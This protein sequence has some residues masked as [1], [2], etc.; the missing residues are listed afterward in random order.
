M[1][2]AAD[3][4]AVVYE[5]ERLRKD[6][7]RLFVDSSA[8]VVKD[9]EG[10]VQYVVLNDRDITPIKYRREAELLQARFRGV[11][12]A[13]PDAIV[14]VDP[15]GRMALVTP[16][17]ERLFGYTREELLGQPV[18][19]LIPDRFRGRHEGH[20]KGYF[21]DP[22]TRTMGSGLELA[23]RRRDG[24]EFPVEI[25]LSLLAIEGATLAMAAIRDVT[26]QKKSERKFRDVLE[27]APDA[28]IIVDR[29][30]RITI[31]NSQTEQVF[32]YSR[33]ELIG[34]PIELLVPTRFH[35]V[36]VSHR[37]NFFGDP[38]RRPMGSGLA[39]SGR[40]KDGTEF[41]VEIS[42]SPV[43]TEEGTL[44]TAAVRDITERVRLEE[45]RRDSAARKVEAEA[46]AKHAGELA[47]SNAELEQF[48]Y[49]ASHD[50][51]EPLRTVGS[52]AQLLAQ[53]YHGRLD[54]EADEF[55]DFVVAAVARMQTM[56]NDLLAFSRVGTRGKPF[57]ATDLEEV[58]EE[59]IANLGRSIEEGGA[60]ITHDPLP[61]VACDRAQLVQVFQNL[62]ANGIKFRGSSPPRIQ[63]S[64]NRLPDEWEF[65]VR[66][67][68]IGIDPKYFD[69]LFIVFQRL[70]GKDEYPGTGIGLAICKKV[71]ERHGGRI[72]VESGLGKGATFRFTIPA[73]KEPTQ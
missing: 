52:F 20:L 41:P 6:G 11:L 13:A 72:W 49:V 27:A 64:W 9:S 54:S 34:S 29:T 67:N 45:I 47:R 36:H 31:A 25:S 59:A 32:G 21:A 61:T 42:L 4:G 18:E 2:V 53:R 8:R 39:L 70:H 10:N 63:V 30:G 46:M 56:I 43:E 3:T 73:R 51:Q 33:D 48:A 50:L 16:E 1:R 19:C 58:F 7:R 69:R 60:I 28:M 71:V 65:A 22:R 38:R 14:L 44:V 26:I 62:L 12:D 57:L 23:G 55:I 37:T 68:G 35:S 5:A 40:R 66:D 15:G 24:T 17:V